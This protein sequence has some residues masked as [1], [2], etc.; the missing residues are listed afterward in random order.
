MGMKDKLETG[1]FNAD[2]LLVN[3]KIYS[4]DGDNRRLSGDTIV[5]IDDK[6]AFAGYEKSPK[7]FIG[8]NTEV[9]DCKGNT[10]LPGLCD[11]HCHPAW[12]IESFVAC[13]LEIDLPFDMDDVRRIAIDGYMQKLKK[14]IELHKNDDIIRG[15]GWD[16]SY[17][18]GIDGKVK[19]PTRHDIDKICNDKP[20]ILNSYCGHYCWVNTKAIEMARLNE[21]NIP[22]L[23]TGI[24]YKEQNGF[25]Q[26]VFQEQAAID[27][28]KEGLEN[29]DY[30]VEQYKTSIRQY[31]AL[32]ANNYGIT[33]VQDCMCSENAKQAYR[34]LA[35]DNELTI[36]VRGSHVIDGT[37]PEDDF[38]EMLANRNKDNVNDLFK[39][40]TAKFF[41]ETGFVISKQKDCPD[42]PDEMQGVLNYSLEDATKY[43]RK[44]MEQGY[45]IHCHAMGDES[46]RLAINAIESARNGEHVGTGRDT[47]AHLM[48]VTNDCIE[49][50]G[51]LGII[52][53]CQP[54]WALYDMEFDTAVLPVF[55]EKR[56]L[57]Q[58][59]PIKKF[60]DAGCRVAYGSDFPVTL[61][62]SPFY[63]MQVA[64][65]RRV[66]KGM[67]DYERYKDKQ[68]G[69][70]GDTGR[71]CVTLQEA[72]KSST[73]DGAYEMFLEE[74]AGSIEKGKSAD[75]V[76]L[77][78]DI[79]S[80]D[81]NEFYAIEVN[82]TIFKGQVVYEV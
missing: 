5:I 57:E 13:P 12:A 34:E 66:F 40:N 2:K 65:T 61:P 1:K 44:A 52:C 14:Y 58:Y 63:S 26:G 30:S 76:I 48:L 19:M 77:N 54:R 67:S 73:Y 55:G 36:R 33:M 68:L 49:K 51:K 64:M 22:E 3:C 16:Y 69:P 39:I 72:V 6:I 53:S 37:T 62:A 71:Y 11:A 32:C 82:K 41:M 46:V 79:E 74:I 21:S 50:L 25:P 43:M 56:A 80:I 23:K 8:K 75:L 27:M 7:N 81:M 10:V 24:I 29:A 4:V 18:K 45:Q 35:R 17:F 9:I 28:L 78:C 42:I 31:Q 60:M 15:Y 47:I 20:V 38:N 70:V 59:Y